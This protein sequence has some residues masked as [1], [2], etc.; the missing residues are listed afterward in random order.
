L[1]AREVAFVTPSPE[2]MD[3]LRRLSAQTWRTSRPLENR[4]IIDDII[5]YQ[6]ARAERQGGA[7]EFNL[8]RQQAAAQMEVVFATDRNDETRSGD[9]GATAPEARFGGK[10]IAGEM[11]CGTIRVSLDQNRPVASEAAG[12][13]H[14]APFTPTPWGADGAGCGALI[15]DRL[16]AAAE[17]DLLLFVHGFNNSFA[18][19]VRRAAALAADISYRGLVG[20]WTWP[21]VGSAFEYKWDDE[22]VQ[23]TR[24][25]LR[26]D[27]K[28]LAGI[29]GLRRVHLVAHSMGGR[30]VLDA[31]EPIAP[32]A[33]GLLPELDDLVFAAPD[34]ASDVF[35]M[36]V[37]QFAA[38]ARRLTLYANG[39]DFALKVSEQWYHAQRRAGQGGNDLV[40]VK[41]LQSI[42]ATGL[43]SGAQHA[44]VFNTPQGVG[45]VEGLIVQDRDAP[46]RGLPEQLRG[47]LRYWLLRPG[48]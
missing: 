45:D 44:Y 16:K 2:G 41:D 27:L 47:Q 42:D 29:A 26:T 18:D 5:A 30:V 23:W 25:H 12:F 33:S 13:I 24:G 9:P 31:L 1:A 17:P 6:Q 43:G 15:A 34:V 28:L 46:A 4:E 37:P 22:S 32:G 36:A 48:S 38:L 19:A 3:A 8:P 40:V 21:S 11:Y 7:P 20:I 39:D 10:R 35:E 14:L